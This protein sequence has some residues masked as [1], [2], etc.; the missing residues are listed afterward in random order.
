[1]PSMTGHRVASPASEWGRVGPEPRAV[2]GIEQWKTG[3]LGVNVRPGRGR[4][5][6][7]QSPEAPR[8]S[9]W[10]AWSGPGWTRSRSSR[11]LTQLERRGT[12]EVIHLEDPVEHIPR[13]KRPGLGTSGV[14]QDTPGIG[15][16]LGQRVGQLAQRLGREPCHDRIQVA[17]EQFLAGEPGVGE[18]GVVQVVGQAGQERDGRIGVEGGRDQD[19]VDRRE[20]AMFVVTLRWLQ[21]QPGMAR[22]GSPGTGLVGQCRD[23]GRKS[24]E[25]VESG[26]VIG[27]R[28]DR[29][30]DIVERARIKQNGD[31]VDGRAQD[32]EDLGDSQPRVLQ[33]R[34]VD[35]AEPGGRQGRS[36]LQARHSARWFAADQG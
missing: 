7:D 1:M 25:T 36:G 11:A 14:S 22:P 33:S 10:K 35:R 8:T 27:E 12:R 26:E 13:V 5:D 28:R 2:L 16:S 34:R 15:D 4:P 29:S 20:V 19:R 6:H 3:D 21:D 30:S 31:R 32:L 24:G 18:P 23:P 9:S 17:A